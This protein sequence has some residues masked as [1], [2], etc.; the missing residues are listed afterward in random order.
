MAEKKSGSWAPRPKKRAEN[1][2]TAVAGCARRIISQSR[3]WMGRDRSSPPGRENLGLDWR[4]TIADPEEEIEE[5]EFDTSLD[6]S[7]NEEAT[8]HLRLVEAIIESGMIEGDWNFANSGALHNFLD[9]IGVDREFGE[10]WYWEGMARMGWP[11]GGYK[12]IPGGTL[13]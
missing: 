2:E 6:N 8:S 4:N 10:K 3:M 11:P 12:P 5:D 9:V 1:W 13:G 7:G